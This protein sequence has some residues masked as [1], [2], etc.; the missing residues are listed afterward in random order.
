MA[1]Q[2]STYYQRRLQVDVN[3]HAST[4]FDRPHIAK[5]AAEGRRS[6]RRGLTHRNAHRAQPDMWVARHDR[7]E[8]FAVFDVVLVQH[9]HE[10]GRAVPS[11]NVA[12]VLHRPFADD[13]GRLDELGPMS[14]RPTY[15]QRSAI[16]QRALTLGLRQSRPASVRCVHETDRAWTVPKTPNFL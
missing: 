5:G 11:W 6:P 12:V 4:I 3:P 7:C 10:A 2:P 16:L 1:A 14:N 9:Q 15:Q 8:K 13:I